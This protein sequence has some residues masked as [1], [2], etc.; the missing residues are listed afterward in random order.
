MCI[1]D[2]STTAARATYADILESEWELVEKSFGEK[3]DFQRRNALMSRYHELSKQG[4]SYHN[5]R[6]GTALAFFFLCSEHPDQDRFGVGLQR[7]LFNYF[8]NPGV[9]TMLT[10]RTNASREQQ[11][12]V[13]S[14]VSDWLISSSEPSLNDRNC[15]LYTSPSPRDGLLSRMPS[16]A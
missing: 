6:A 5:C 10:R 11:D 14:L 1:R 13:R 4:L 7:N 3:D 15:L 16:S 12:V 8:R 2:R 9:L